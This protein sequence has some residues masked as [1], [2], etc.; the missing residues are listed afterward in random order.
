M[1]LAVFLCV[2]CA[3]CGRINTQEYSINHQRNHLM[4]LLD[5]HR[6]IPISRIIQSVFLCEIIQLSC[7]PLRNLR[8]LRENIHVRVLKQSPKTPKNIRLSLWT[9]SATLN[10]LQAILP[11][12]S[13]TRHAFKQQLFYPYE[14]NKSATVFLYLL[15]SQYDFVFLTEKES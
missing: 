11:R 2:I 5:L 3:I 6:R 15:H 8:D 13:S 4:S 1:Q 10:I 14:A 9:S 12:P 7:I